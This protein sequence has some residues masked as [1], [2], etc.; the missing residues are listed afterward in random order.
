MT[1]TTTTVRTATLYRIIDL[2][3]ASAGLGDA[4]VLDS[5]PGPEFPHEGIGFGD[6]TAGLPAWAAMKSGRV[7]A[8]DGFGIGFIVWAHR[9]GQDARQARQR[10]EDLFMVLYN[11]LANSPKLGGEVAGLLSV[12]FGAVNGPDAAPDPNGGGYDAW[13]TGQ[14]ACRTRVS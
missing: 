11:E 3:R 14:I 13:I 12:R 1:T 10:C 5:G 4:A 9:E 8:D 6:I 2:V 7:E